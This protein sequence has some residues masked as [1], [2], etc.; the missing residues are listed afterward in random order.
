MLMRIRWGSGY[1]NNGLEVR[2]LRS[3][4]ISGLTLISDWK[5][6]KPRMHILGQSDP[7]PDAGEFSGHVKCEHGCLA[8]NTTARRRISAEVKHVFEIG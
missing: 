7:P 5:L 2:R 3:F 8:L 4:I 1:P 6:T